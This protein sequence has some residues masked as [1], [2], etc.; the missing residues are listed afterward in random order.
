[1]TRKLTA[2]QASVGFYD[3]AIAALSMKAALEAWGA[4]SNPFHQGF[5][6]ESSHPEV[7]AAT[8]SKPGV[9]L[10]R[11]VGSDAPF[12]EHPDPP[13]QLADAEPRHRP[14]KISA[15]SKERVPR[16]TDK[17]ARKAII[18]FEKEQRRR[19]DQRR[20][21]DAVGQKQQLWTRLGGSMK[22]GW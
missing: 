15:R 10:R 8:M 9:V 4:G 11:P 5:A 20:K 12:S 3:L 19:E 18:A 6:N 1:M 13:T 16:S 14:K 21:E 17:A 22:R 7:I 2:Y